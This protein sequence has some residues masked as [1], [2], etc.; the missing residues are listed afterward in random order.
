[1]KHIKLL[2][3]TIITASVLA[4]CSQPA[5]DTYDPSKLQ[6][7]V[8]I[9]PQLELVRAIGG[10]HVQVTV[11]VP[12]GASPETYEPTPDQMQAV[13]HGQVYFKEGILPF[14]QLNLDKL[15][16]VNS[17]LDIVD[18]SVSI[19]YRQIEEEGDDEHGHNGH[20]HESGADP[21]V[22]NDPN[23]V[24]LQAVIVRDTLIKLHPNQKA[25]FEANYQSY[26]NQLTDLDTYLRQAFAPLKGKEI[27][28]Y[29]PAFGYLTDRYGLVQKPIELS[30][31]E[32]SP[33]KVQEIINQAKVDGVKVIFVQKQFNTKA[34]EV[35]ASE[36]GGKVVTIDP[37]AADYV[38]NL[39]QLAH[40][41]S[42]NLTNSH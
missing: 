8:T 29:H 30:G 14:E 34:S 22:W 12:P 42:Q 28:V 35:N 17:K 16:Q 36:I 1:M 11:M 13:A 5:T 3:L 9:P 40:T 41:I 25:T 39:R 6:V 15:L 24:M 7:I 33:V 32:P 19:D 23:N 21:H 38:A 20:E 4:G 31:K 18:T 37:L 26:I 2:A 10:D 27:L